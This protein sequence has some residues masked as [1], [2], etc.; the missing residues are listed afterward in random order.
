MDTGTD[1]K[2]ERTRG[3]W[4]RAGESEKCAKLAGTST[5]EDHREEVGCLLYT[6]DA[7]DEERLV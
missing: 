7:A 6:S 4:S 3:I 5:E 1:S 2:G